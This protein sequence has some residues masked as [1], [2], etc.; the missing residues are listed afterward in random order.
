MIRENS[1]SGKARGKFR[2]I[3]STAGRAIRIFCNIDVKPEGGGGGSKAVF[4]YCKNHQFL[5]LY[6]VQKLSCVSGAGIF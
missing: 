5:Y 1:L 6:T 2:K 3:T 4:G